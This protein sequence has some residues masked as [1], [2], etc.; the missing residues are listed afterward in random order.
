MTRWQW[1]RFRAYWAC[2]ERMH[3]ISWWLHERGLHWLGARFRVLSK[4]E[5][6][7]LKAQKRLTGSREHR[8][9]QQIREAQNLVRRRKWK[10]E[11]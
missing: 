9:Y 3:A 6:A 7:T 1:F 4:L 10:G 8:L 2:Y 11:W 5:K